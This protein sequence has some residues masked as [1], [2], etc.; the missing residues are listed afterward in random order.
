MSRPLAD[1]LRGL[2]RGAPAERAARPAPSAP[3]AGEGG[4][5]FRLE[6][7]RFPLAHRHG[8]GPLSDALGT[9]CAEAAALSGKCPDYGLV[10]PERRLY[11]DTE[12]TGL[13]GGAGCYVFLVGLGSF[14]GGEFVVRQYLMRDPGEEPALLEALVE[15]FAACEALVTFCGKSFDLPRCQDRLL[16]HRLEGRLAL[17]PHL[18]LYHAARRQLGH[19]QADARLQTCEREA[20]G[21]QREDDL[22]SADCPQAWL[23]AV[24]GGETA[25]LER[26]LEHN[27]LDILSLVRL[28]AHLASGLGAPRDDAE[29]LVAVEL[30][31]EG[32]DYARARELVRARGG[33]GA[34]ASRSAWPLPASVTATRRAV[35]AL[36]KAEDAEGAAALARVGCARWPSDEG[37]VRDAATVLSRDL[38][39]GARAAALLREVAAARGGDRRLE[40]RA[41]QLMRRGGA[42]R[43]PG[44]EA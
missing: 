27:L 43:R 17:V 35:R 30:A 32:E 8:E 3:E 5:G 11:L 40:D 42:T 33:E 23:D 1:R 39:D 10:A 16:L 4:P 37:L 13:F 15:R 24:R 9:A 25:A 18:D 19:R 20:L 28:E 7:H 31:V 41:V 2:K 34:P 26:V 36:R 38:R 14:E 21:F 22:P 44:K 6:E 29:R 12:T